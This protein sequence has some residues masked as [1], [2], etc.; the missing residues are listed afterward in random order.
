MEN[1]SKALLIAGGILLVMLIIG[2]LIFSWNKFSDFYSRNDD[3]SKFNLQ[4]TNYENRKVYGYELISL[5]NKVAD[6]NMRYSNANGAQNDEKYTPITMNFTM[7]EVQ[8][9]SL[10]FSKEIP[11]VNGKEMVISQKDKLFTRT[12]YEQSTTRNE[13]IE[14]IFNE[15]VR[16]EDIYRG[17]AI[18][19]KLAKSVNSLI[20]DQNQLDYNYNNKQMSYIQS[21]TNSIMTYNSIVDA[22]DKIEYNI[23]GMDANLINNYVENKYK[24][25]YTKLINEAS[26]MKYYEFYQF[27]RGIFKCK[28]ITDNNY[29]KVSG[30]I[31]L[32]E[33]EFTGKIE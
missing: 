12:K 27:K 9:D 10:R 26:V 5:A 18:A 6:Y 2:L 16:I 17:S 7:T 19:T 3:L 28:N 23:E 21:K 13:I 1:A 29:D 8:A 32:I 20:L 4:F 24:E 31:N 15:A 30:R 11:N 14:Q 25:M 22:K 33:F